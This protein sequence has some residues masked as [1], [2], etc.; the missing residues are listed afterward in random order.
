[1]PAASPWIWVAK[2]HK[3]MLYVDG[4][5]WLRWQQEDAHGGML[6]SSDSVMISVRHI[7]I[8]MELGIVNNKVVSG[9]S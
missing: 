3:P 2:L 6:N 1:M 5:G 7:R 4:R 9:P 8:L